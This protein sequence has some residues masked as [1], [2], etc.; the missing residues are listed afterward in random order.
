MVA[1]PR[2]IAFTLDLDGNETKNAL[3]GAPP[4]RLKVGRGV[5]LNT[6]F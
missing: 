3:L 2:S 1:V 5:G 4:P 6:S